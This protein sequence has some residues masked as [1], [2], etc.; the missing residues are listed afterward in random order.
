MSVTRPTFLSPDNSYTLLLPVVLSIGAETKTISS[1]KLRRQKGFD[2]LALDGAPTAVQ[3]V[4]TMLE[5]MTGQLR[6]VTNKMDAVDIDRVEQCMRYFREPTSLMADVETFI[7]GQRPP[8]LK[9]DNS[10]ELLVPVERTVAGSAQKV[11][12][13]QLRRLVGADMMLMDGP[14]SATVKLFAVLEEMTGLPRDITGEMD[15]VDLDRIDECIGYFREPGSVI[16]A[17]S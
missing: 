4:F 10:Y 17:I 15:A 1:V 2:L 5:A 12:S 11:T 9:P 3:R 16:G 8:Y 7:D 13:V 6:V 14:L